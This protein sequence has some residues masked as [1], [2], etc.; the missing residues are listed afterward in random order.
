VCGHFDAVFVVVVV[1]IDLIFVGFVCLLLWAFCFFVVFLCF[2]SNY[3]SHVCI[4]YD[5]LRDKKIGFTSADANAQKWFI[6]PLLFL[7]ETYTMYL[8]KK[9]HFVYRFV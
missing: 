9:H 6:N 3:T 2:F 4:M 5:V 1:V 8:K 7:Q